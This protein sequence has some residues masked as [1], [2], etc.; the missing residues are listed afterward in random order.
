MIRWECFCSG[1]EIRHPIVVLSFNS[2]LYRVLIVSGIVHGGIT[3]RFDENIPCNLCKYD[4]N[5]AV[6]NVPYILGL[7]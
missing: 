6:R 1:A 4:F 2:M 3:V 7:L 5:S